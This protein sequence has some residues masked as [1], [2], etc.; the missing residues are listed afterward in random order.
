MR[1]FPPNQL[2]A[3]ATIRSGLVN[4]L[5][6]L[7]LGVTCCGQFHKR[8]RGETQWVLLKAGLTKRPNSIDQYATPDRMPVWATKFL[9]RSARKLPFLGPVDRQVLPTA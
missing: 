3:G 4:S 9:D 1:H 2:L 5:L 7:L 8:L 6:N